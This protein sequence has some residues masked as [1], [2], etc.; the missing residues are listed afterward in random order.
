MTS[1]DDECSRLSPQNV[2][3]GTE[4][5]KKRGKL[6]NPSRQK[7]RDEEDFIPQNGNCV[8][9]EVTLSHNATPSNHCA[10]PHRDRTTS[11]LFHK[12]EDP[13]C[14]RIRPSCLHSPPPKEMSS[15]TFAKTQIGT[16]YL[17]HLHS[18]LLKILVQNLISLGLTYGLKT[19]LSMVIKWPS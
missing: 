6:K 12:F 11:W 8:P 9:L 3:L 14:F 19:Q 7:S 10:C 17:L 15:S 5:C 2:T 13:P 4:V 18:P 1:L 16:S